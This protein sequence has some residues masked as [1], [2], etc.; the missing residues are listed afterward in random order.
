DDDD[1][2]EDEDYIVENG[3]I[4]DGIDL[5]GYARKLTRTKNAD[6]NLEH[7]KP[8]YICMFGN[9]FQAI[10]NLSKKEFIAFARTLVHQEFYGVLKDAAECLEGEELA[11]VLMEI[12]IRFY[13]VKEFLDLYLDAFKG[14]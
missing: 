13:S 5:F 6:N 10:S 7:Y 12:I 4:D 2:D 11:N 14:R 9:I 3:E 1:A 8:S